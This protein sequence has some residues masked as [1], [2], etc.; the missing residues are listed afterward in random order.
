MDTFACWVGR[1][2]PLVRGAGDV[3]VVVANRCGEEG[4]GDAVGEEKGGVR[5]AGTSWVGRMGGGRVRVGGMMGRGVEGVMVVDLGEGGG[6]ESVWEVGE[7]EGE[8]DGGT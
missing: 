3:V 6:V 2:V 1:L 7:G 8:V 5:Y 4:G